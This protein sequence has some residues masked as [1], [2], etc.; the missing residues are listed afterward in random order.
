LY[1]A[2][3]AQWRKKYAAGTTAT[4]PASS[5]DHDTN[6]ERKSC[7]VMQLFDHLVGAYQESFGDVQSQRLGG[8]HVDDQLEFRCLLDWQVRGFGAL[9]NLVHVQGALAEQGGYVCTVG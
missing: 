8:L 9:Q 3:K 1:V 4:T 2:P 6:G 5:A 7:E